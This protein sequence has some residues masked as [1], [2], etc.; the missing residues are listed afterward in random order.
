[1]FHV[2]WTIL[3]ETL[4]LIMHLFL[5]LVKGLVSALMVV[6]RSGVLQTVISIGVDLL[7]VMVTELL[8]PYM[9]A[10]INA[11][12]CIIDMFTTSTWRGQLECS[13]KRPTTPCPVC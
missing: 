5:L 11:V 8:I 6:I 2:I 9:L 13:E 3:S 12:V 7:V 1:V 4:E 10:L